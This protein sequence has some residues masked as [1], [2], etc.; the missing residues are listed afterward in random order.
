MLCTE[1]VVWMKAKVQALRGQSGVRGRVKK[2]RP[3]KDH[4]SEFTEK[5]ETVAGL[6]MRGTGR[7]RE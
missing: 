1:K 2:Q 6:P 5:E 7:P 3:Y 4:G